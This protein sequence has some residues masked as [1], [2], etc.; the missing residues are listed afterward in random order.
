ML[1]WRVS[2]SLMIYKK[3]NVL[4]LIDHRLTASRSGWLWLSITICQHSHLD[5]ALSNFWWH[6]LNIPTS[7]SNNEQS[8]YQ[9]THSKQTD[10]GKCITMNKEVTHLLDVFNNFSVFFFNQLPFTSLWHFCL[11]KKLLY[12][13]QHSS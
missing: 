5:L 3:T 10:L 1:L 12:C 6:K 13:N 7:H 11:K 2:C 9:T 8:C 4:V